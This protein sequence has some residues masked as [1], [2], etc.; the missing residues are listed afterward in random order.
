MNN[1]QIEDVFG[2]PLSGED[3]GL[4][5]SLTKLEKI[6]D[7]PFGISGPH[8]HASKE[9]YKIL[10]D[11]ETMEVFKQIRQPGQFV[12]PDFFNLEYNGKIFKFGDDN[13]VIRLIG[14]ARP[15]SQ[16]ELLQKNCEQLG[17]ENPKVRMSGDLGDTH[18]IKIINP[19]SGN[20]VTLDSG[21]IVAQNH[22]HFTPETAEKYNVKDGSTILVGLKNS[23]G[24][25]LYDDVIAK[26]S[27]YFLDE[28]HIDSEQAPKKLFGDT[29]E[30]TVF[31]NLK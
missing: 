11:K 15:Q 12:T 3:A 14:P 13:A 31:K 4:D 6:L 1:T 16:V 2:A 24:M 28:I 20:Y 25:R 8:F 30:A 19:I 7:M 26:V 29:L 5:T 21:V 17:I 9:H 22:G 23:Y 10:M 27:P 18:G